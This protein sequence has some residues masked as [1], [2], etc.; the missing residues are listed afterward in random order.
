MKLSSKFR[1]Y[2]ILVFATFFALHTVASAAD[3]LPVS[4]T[5]TLASVRISA[6]VVQAIVSVFL[7]LV[8]GF[9]TSIK[10]SAF[11]KGILQ[12]VLNAVSAFIVQYTLLDGSVVFSKST[13]M[14]FLVGTATSLVSY[15]NIWKTRGLTSSLV[16]V[17]Q[18]DG[19]VAHVPGQLSSVGLRKAA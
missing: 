5:D 10:D 7:P 3:V 1:A 19:S 18:A 17:K 6:T 13:V 15:Y 14:V 8:V 2:L 12:L 9:V 11:L 4:P 16:T